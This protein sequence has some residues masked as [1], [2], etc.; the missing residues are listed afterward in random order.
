MVLIICSSY[1]YI[2]ICVCVCVC[3][4]VCMCVCVCVC[5]F[6]LLTLCFD[7]KCTGNLDFWK[8]GCWRTIQSLSKTT[9]NFVINL[10]N[11]YKYIFLNSHTSWSTNLCCLRGQDEDNNY[12]ETNRKYQKNFTHF[13]FLN[14][15]FFGKIYSEQL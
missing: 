13:I 5:M 3:V 4:C 1:I 2:Y 15:I 12:S 10:F 11:T 6:F 7:F 8:P 9:N 14:N